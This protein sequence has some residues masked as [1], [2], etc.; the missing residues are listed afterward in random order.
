MTEEQY[1]R[2]VQI[3]NRI[4]TL[5]NVK[6]EIEG[7]RD[8]RLWYAEKSISS[9]DFRLCSEYRMRDISDILDKHDTMIRAEIDEERETTEEETSEDTQ[10]VLCAADVSVLCCAD[11]CQHPIA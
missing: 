10:H 9:S 11:W 3:S 1:I 4:E 5:N 6:K 7:T 2:A 8:H